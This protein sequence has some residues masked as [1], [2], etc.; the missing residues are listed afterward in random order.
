MAVLTIVLARKIVKTRGRELKLSN[1]RRRSL[2]GHN[3][4]PST[5]SSST[6][7]T[8]KICW[9]DKN[10]KLFLTTANKVCVWDNSFCSTVFTSG[11]EGILAA[12]RSKDGAILAVADAQIVVLHKV[13][14]GQHQSYRLKGAEGNCRLLQYAHD[15]KSLF[16]TDSIHN[17]VQTYSLR[18]DRVNEAAKA[19]PSVITSFCV[20]PDS[21]FLLS[22]SADPP[23]I[24]LHNRQLNTTVDIKPKASS[25]PVV[26]CAFHPTRKSTFVLAFADGALAAYDSTRLVRGDKARTTARKGNVGS[27]GGEHIHS[28]GHLHDAS[29]SGGAGITGV[30]FI[31]GYRTRAVS[32][33]EDGRLFIVDFENKDVLG[34]WH[35]G[36][37]ATCV[38]VRPAVGK[39]AGKSSTDIGWMVAVGTI[40]GKCFVF[41]GGGTKVCEQTV[42]DEAG[43]VLDVEWVSGEVPLPP[44]A[45]AP[46]SILPT[47]KS[48]AKS[49]SS[50][51]YP[52]STSSTTTHSLTG[53]SHL[54][55]LSSLEEDSK[56]ATNASPP[57]EIPNDPLF[58]SES[59][60]LPPWQEVI[61]SS[62][63]K[64]MDMFSPVKK[65]KP[66]KA[67]SVPDK[68]SENLIDL[69]DPKERAN[70]RTDQRS[71]I[72][73][74]L[75]WDDKPLGK[76]HGP[77]PAS[78]HTSSLGL[79]MLDGHGSREVSVAA[80]EA[81]HTAKDVTDIGALEAHE[82]DES[83]TKIPEKP[84]STVYS[85]I[86]DPRKLLSDI[87]SIR[88]D[89]D[90]GRGTRGLALFAPYMRTR[91]DF[92]RGNL[93][94]VAGMKKTC[95]TGDESTLSGSSIHSEPQ[96][97]SVGRPADRDI[98]I[99]D[100]SPAKDES[101]HM[102]L[103]DEMDHIV[104]QEKE[105]DYASIS[106]NIIE[107]TSSDETDIWLVQGLDDDDQSTPKPKTEPREHLKRK[108][109]SEEAY[110]SGDATSLST[111]DAI[112]S[113]GSFLSS[114]LSAGTGSVRSP[115][116]SNKSRK[117]APEYNRIV[118]MVGTPIPTPSSSLS[119]TGHRAQESFKT[120]TVGVG[121][122][123][124]QSGVPGGVGWEEAMTRMTMEL[125]QDIKAMHGDILK[126]FEEQKQMLEEVSR[127]SVALRMENERL[128]RELF[129]IIGSRS[130][131]VSGTFSGAPEK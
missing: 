21:N 116:G 72:S 45:G 95:S 122:P 115:S 120:A 6:S 14:Q 62:T 75:L 111:K 69:K 79:A 4:V 106:T 118:A 26:C 117:V 113:K 114:K 129:E 89:M 104:E 103:E 22:C 64:Y 126:R 55:T 29:I 91:P 41:D 23:V 110:G 46:E 88:G 107:D 1:D 109:L 57:I 37:P 94:G 25:R 86:T 19:H 73:A 66:N 77:T 49:P 108:V 71:V 121:P 84:V 38:S 61:D 58:L 97:Q 101:V 131:T 20:S 85:S 5:N 82:M 100:E 105:R 112:N 54:P 74:P 47:S 53:K 12:K 81:S 90:K 2:R 70:E 28:F 34:S 60:N 15:S 32:V 18:E 9:D 42:D 67:M 36:A 130:R 78:T 59:S 80:S 10:W 30:E 3:K 11:S 96:Q 102:P 93:E 8:P 123:G 44:A 124:P 48:T 51:R 128:R 52:E 27:G 24:Q 56:T 76:K 33:G 99:S 35:V 50:S 17:S 7:D 43:K 39:D 68:E 83:S 65:K 125:R 63:A 119:V 87:K 40:H 13:D 31:P 127:E 98:C 92:R 16:F